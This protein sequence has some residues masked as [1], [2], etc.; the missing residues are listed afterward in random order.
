VVYLGGYSDCTWK[1]IESVLGGILSRS[2]GVCHRVQ[3]GESLK[4]C[5]GVNLGFNLRSTSDRTQSVLESVLRA[6]LGA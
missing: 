5:L 4:A 6:Y 3:S 2:L 1:C